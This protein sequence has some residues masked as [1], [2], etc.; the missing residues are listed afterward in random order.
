M[1]ENMTLKEKI[2][3]MLMVGMDGNKIDNRIKN[4]I[5][6]YKISGVILYRKNFK[7]YDDMI[8]LISELKKINSNNKVPLFIAIDQEGGRVN[9][10]PPEFHNLLS[11]YKLASAKNLEL[12]KEAGDITGEMLQKSGYNMN[13][14]PV[15]DLLKKETSNAI[16]NRSF[17]T[18]ARDVSIYGTEMMKQLQKHQIISVIKHFPGMG[19]TKKDSHYRLPRIR[20]IDE[21]DVQ[22]FINAIENGADAMMVG[23]MIVRNISRIYPASLSQKVI[24]KIRLKYKFNGVI[25]TDDLKMRAIRY[26]YGTKRALKQAIRAGNDLI[27]FRFKK[28]DEIEAIDEIFQLVQSGKIK[29]RRIDKSVKRILKLKE[30]Y[31]IDDNVSIEKCNIEEINNR[32]DAVNEVVKR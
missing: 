28:K 8:N 19:A 26:I 31:N 7:N 14:S 3:Q 11:A 16:G 18:N 20:N 9:R 22:P 23:H 30:K 17:G 15:L 29:E 10:M 24:K 32:I 4:L 25:V 5:V 12:I 2:G 21:Q 1:V 13:F 27:L 6:N